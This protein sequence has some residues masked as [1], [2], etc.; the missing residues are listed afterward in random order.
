M[1]RRL[2]PRR[3]PRGQRSWQRPLGSTSY[4]VMTPAAVRQLQD[5]RRQ[6]LNPTDTDHA[7]AEPAPT[8][9]AAA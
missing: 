3:D 1:G 5:L 4:V 8:L 2:A 6:L 9:T 7:L